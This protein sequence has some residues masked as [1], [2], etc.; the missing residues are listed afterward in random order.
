MWPGQ[1]RDSVPTP[2]KASCSALESKNAA[3][4]SGPVALAKD[5]SRAFSLLSTLI[6]A[7]VALLVKIG[8]GMLTPVLTKPLRSES[9]W[10]IE[11]YTAIE[12]LW[13]CVAGI[14]ACAFGAFAAQRFGAKP[15]TALGLSLSETSILSR[16]VQLALMGSVF[17]I[18]QKQ[19]RRV[20]GNT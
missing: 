19:T 1:R 2:G 18:D 9:G 8:C 14:M 15:V 5:L 20:L 12:G 4:A 6:G 11:E 17:L 7:S 3:G 13:G 16:M 10:T